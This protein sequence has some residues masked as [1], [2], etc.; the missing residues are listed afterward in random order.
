MKIQSDEFFNEYK[1]VK[2]EEEI[3]KSAVESVRYNFNISPDEIIITDGV[4]STNASDSHLIGRGKTAEELE[5]ERMRLLALIK[6]K[7]VR[8]QISLIEASKLLQDVNVAYNTSIDA[9]EIAQVGMG[10]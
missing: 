8:R 1:R 5:N 9:Q 4:L 2:R 3:R 6:E 10:R 7:V